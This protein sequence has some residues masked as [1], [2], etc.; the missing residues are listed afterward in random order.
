MLACLFIF[1]GKKKGLFTFDTNRASKLAKIRCARG[2]EHSSTKARVEGETTQREYRAVV[3]TSRPCLWSRQLRAVSVNADVFRFKYS[4][5][6]HVSAVVITINKTLSRAQFPIC[7]KSKALLQDN[8][9]KKTH[10][11]QTTASSTHTRT[12]QTLSARCIITRNKHG[13]KTVGIA[14]HSRPLNKS[15]TAVAMYMNIPTNRQQRLT[16]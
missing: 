13:K 9:K 16:N 8:C 11:P 10:R 12:R 7:T 2:H 1:D 3:E 15:V 14:K 6:T 4:S 5:I